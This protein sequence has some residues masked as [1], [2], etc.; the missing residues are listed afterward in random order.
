MA[1]RI[2]VK[3]VLYI[4]GVEAECPPIIRDVISPDA[5][6]YKAEAAGIARRDNIGE[7]VRNVVGDR[8]KS[9]A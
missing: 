6:G 8:T 9:V 1:H 5:T 3:L 2:F 4:H 7:I